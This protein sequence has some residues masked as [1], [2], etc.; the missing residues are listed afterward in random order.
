MNEAYVE[1]MVERKPN[2]LTKVLRIA[3]IAL[4]VILCAIGFVTMNFYYLIPAVVLGLVAYFLLPRLEVEFEYLYLDKEI[5]I[6]KIFS[7]QSRKRAM[8]I[9]LNKMEIMAPATS[10]EFD[11]YR[12]RKV[13][14]KDFSSKNPEVKPYGIAYRDAS[15]DML[16]LFEPNAEMLKAIRTVFP[17]KVL[18]F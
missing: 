7:K 14:V 8:V 16:I 10:H 15:G 3:V 17:R 5:T 9:D 13:P 1:Y 11:S 6:D 4:A 12:N 2:P 18:D